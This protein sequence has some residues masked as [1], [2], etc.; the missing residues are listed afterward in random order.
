MVSEIGFKV[1]SEIVITG[2]LEI[3]VITGFGTWSLKGSKGPEGC[4]REGKW[5]SAESEEVK[6]GFFAA[7]AAFTDFMTSFITLTLPS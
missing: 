1:V 4:L 5:V 2:V 3:L 7:S 6:Q